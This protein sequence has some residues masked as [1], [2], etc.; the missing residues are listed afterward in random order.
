MKKIKITIPYCC[1][2][3]FTPSRLAGKNLNRIHDPSSGGIGIKL[4]IPHKK[5]Y[6][7]IMPSNSIN[8]TV[9]GK[10]KNLINN[11]KNIAMAKFDKGPAIETFKVPHF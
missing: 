11:P 1:K 4:N 8:G 7:V 10:P 5:L 2:N 3:A 9:C 6:I